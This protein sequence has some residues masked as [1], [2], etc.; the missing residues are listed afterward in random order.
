MALHITKILNLYMYQNEKSSWTNPAPRKVSI[1]SYQLDGQYD[2][3]FD[4]GTL[5][6]K[7]N[8][9]FNISP[10]D[11]YA[12]RRIEKGTSICV[13]FVSDPPL[14]T[15]LIDCNDDPRFA[16]LFRKLLTY[17]NIGIESNYYMALS[18]IYEIIGLIEK[19]KASEYLP[20]AMKNHFSEVHDYLLNHFYDSN[21]DL[22]AFPKKFGLS[23]KYFREKFR[24]LYGSTPTQYLI[25][26]RLNEAAKLLSEGF[27]SI[28][29][30]AETVGIPDVYY[31]SRLFKKKFSVSPS[32]FSVSE[33]VV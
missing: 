19:Q 14:Q 15:E 25:S 32:Q 16:I 5:K 6:V 17:R 30:V 23:D 3:L 9:I 26:L 33:Y 27:L 12:V 20:I 13:T 1:L 24:S 4:F 11:T 29:E 18:I 21:L 10:H 2:H 7:S 8:H 28:S 31:F 22:T